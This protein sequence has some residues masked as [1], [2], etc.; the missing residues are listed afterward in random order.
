[1]NG[2]HSSGLMNV[3]PTPMKIRMTAI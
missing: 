2:F 3:I 1:M